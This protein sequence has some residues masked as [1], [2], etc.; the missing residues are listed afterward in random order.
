MLEG[1]HEVGRR[2]FMPDSTLNR[3]SVALYVAEPTQFSYPQETAECLEG[4]HP[5]VLIDEADS[6]G[7]DN[8]DLRNIVNGGFERGRPAIRVNKETLQPEFL[9]TFGCKLLASIGALHETIEDRSVIIDMKRK[10]PNFAIEELCDA[11]TKLFLDTRR[12]IQRWV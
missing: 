11:D 5:T 9:D 8:D 10:P 6:Y 3:R 12:K 2:P 4:F 1:T 7:K